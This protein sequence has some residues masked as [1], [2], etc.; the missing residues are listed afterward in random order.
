MTPRPS[1]TGA[2]PHHRPARPPRPASPQALTT[3]LRERLLR[4]PRRLAR[5]V[6]R[7]DQEGLPQAGPPAAP[8]RQLR[9][10]RRRSG[11]R[12][13]AGPT[14][15]CRTPSAARSTTWAATRTASGGGFGPGFG[16]SDIFETFFGAA[17]GAQRGPTP[18]QRRGQD[19]L[20]RIE[21]DLDEATFG[22]QRELQIDTA[23]VCPTC[24]GTC[25]RP[26]TAPQICD[27][28]K[29]RGQVQRVARSFLGQVMTTQ[30]CARLP[31]VR[32]A[33]SP[34]PAWSAP[35]RAGS[36]PAGTPHHQDPGRRRHRHPD[37]ARRAGRGRPRRR[38][39]RR[40]VRRDRRA[41]APGLHPSRRRP[42][43]HRSRSR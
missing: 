11:S 4:D 28:C 2:P 8:G 20:I 21:V 40:P 25:C 6:D 9:A 26:G 29:G 5:R 31:R 23:V 17:A 38:P 15:C 22:G 37:P 19:A 3:E 10:R 13:S 41:A 18:R 34:T 33:S 24:Q 7:R 14:R 35:A 32:H 36:A 12:R 1:T 16:F 43:L 42:A 30:P 27:V 39:A